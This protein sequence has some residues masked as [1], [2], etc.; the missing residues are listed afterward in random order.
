MLR[1]IEDDKEEIEY[2]LL[3]AFSAHIDSI[4]YGEMSEVY[5][6]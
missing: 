3:G 5:R 6:N 1:T 4:M 2:A